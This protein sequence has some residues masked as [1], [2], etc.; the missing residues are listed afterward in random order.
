M[1]KL[2]SECYCFNV[3]RVTAKVIRLYDQYLLESGVSAQQY[4]VLK[5]I[6]HL[7]PITLTDLSSVLG[8]DRTTLSR[9]AKILIE[10]GLIDYNIP[11]GR[12]KKLELTR[13]GQD[14]F[15]LAT[16]QWEKAQKIFEDQLGAEKLQ[17]WNRLINGLL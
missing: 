10:K 6:H 7:S 8:L 9:N 4:T 14:T 15:L 5:A 2:L 17:E 12:G 13:K 16:T 3:R 1:E 11:K